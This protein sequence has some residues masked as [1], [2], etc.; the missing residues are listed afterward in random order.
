MEKLWNLFE[1][2]PSVSSFINA[3]VLI[4]IAL[5]ALIILISIIYTQIKVRIFK[6]N[7]GA[8]KVK[9]KEVK[10]KESYDKTLRG[11]DVTFEFEHNGK[12][13]EETIFSSK[14]FKINSIRDG[15]Y[16]EG[17]KKNLLS[18]EGQGFY[19]D[20]GAGFLGITFAV[21][22]LFLIIGVLLNVSTR[23]IIDSTL[24]YLLLL[25]SGLTIRHF[26]LNKNKKEGKEINKKDAIFYNKANYDEYSAVDSNLVRY[27]P[28]YKKPKRK[29]AKGSLLFRCIFIGLGGIS[30]IIGIF[31]L[32]DV[33]KTI[34]YYDNTFAEISE[35]YTYRIHE[36]SRMDESD[37]IGVIYIYEVNGN[38]YTSNNKTGIS[39]EM[40]FKKV[41]DKVKI[42]YD[43]KDPN[44]SISKESIPSAILPIIIGPLFLYIG[45]QNIIEENK[46]KRLY[47]MYVKLSEES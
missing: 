11:Y 3:L 45:I 27:I 9:V 15:L 28:K 14:N 21:Y 1:S 35:I 47:D 16:L 13:K 25:F 19:V 22:L 46:K 42:Y 17:K 12:L 23:I 6:K 7:A 26:I 20:K 44:I 41:G 4:L 29:N 34:V 43:K 32:I 24:L 5:I 30:T 36:P 2:L 10:R 8:V 39:K 37:L 31:T 40:Y 38:K 33:L 18:V